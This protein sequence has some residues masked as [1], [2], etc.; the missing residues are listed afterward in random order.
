MKSGSKEPDFIKAVIVFVDIEASNIKLSGT[1]SAITTNLDGFTLMSNSV[2]D[3]CVSLTNSTNI[4]LISEDSGGFS[5]AEINAAD[6][7]DGQ[8]ADVYGLYNLEGCLV[9][10]SILAGAN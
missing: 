8:Q 10:D 9:A 1:I 3:V 6:L 7:A 2:G 4:F 5:S